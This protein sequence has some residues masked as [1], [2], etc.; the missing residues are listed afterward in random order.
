MLGRAVFFMVRDTHVSRAAGS[1][2]PL[3]PNRLWALQGWFEDDELTI[4]RYELDPV[5]ALISAP[6]YFNQCWCQ[7][8]AYCQKHGSN[9]YGVA[10]SEGSLWV[11][12][13]NQYMIF[14]SFLGYVATNDPAQ[15]D[16]EFWAKKARNKIEAA[17]RKEK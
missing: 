14:N 4:F 11:L 12:D 13:S 16:Q 9:V 6:H 8:R 3:A 7:D 15:I 17:K 1:L 2:C 10:L 5:I